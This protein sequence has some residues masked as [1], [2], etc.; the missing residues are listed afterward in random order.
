MTG[1]GFEFVWAAYGLT[2]VVLVTYAVGLWVRLARESRREQDAQAPEH[3]P[4][5]TH[6]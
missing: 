2:A 6:V 4:E 1:N 5:A 3:A